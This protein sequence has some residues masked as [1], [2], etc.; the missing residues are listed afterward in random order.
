MNTSLYRFEIQLS[1]NDRSHVPYPI[2]QPRFVIGN[3]HNADLHLDD[4]DLYA[5]VTVNSNDRVNIRIG[6]NGIVQTW[7]PDSIVKIGGYEFRLLRLKVDTSD[8]PPTEEPAPLKPT[9]PPPPPPSFPLQG[10][11]TL[12]WADTVNMETTQER[13]I[14]KQAYSIGKALDN[15]LV[16]EDRDHISP[17][18][19]ILH[20]RGHGIILENQSEFGTEVESRIDGNHLLSDSSPAMLVNNDQFYIGPY[21]FVLHVFE[22]GTD[23]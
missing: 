3:T 20:F 7:E 14:Q 16:L 9:P 8:E 1:A 13:L 10:R 23:D 4:Q 21:Q 11:V 12:S 18:H 5:V 6:K 22:P 2:T 19:A 17:H 15:D